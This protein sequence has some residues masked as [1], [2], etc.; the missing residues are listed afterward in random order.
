MLR[1]I[2]ASLFLFIVTWHSDAC[3]TAKKSIIYI[4]GLPCQDNKQKIQIPLRYSK[5]PKE[6]KFN[7]LMLEKS[8]LIALAARAAAWKNNSNIDDSILKKVNAP[9][10]TALLNRVSKKVKWLNT[11]VVH[12]DSLTLLFKGEGGMQINELASF[13]GPPNNLFIEQNRDD[14]LE[15]AS[16]LVQEEKVRNIGQTIEYAS[17]ERTIESS[18]GFKGYKLEHNDI[19]KDQSRSIFQI[20]SNRYLVKYSK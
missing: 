13:N 2:A 9:S 18:V 14:N 1:D 4:N 19:Y 6:L 5:A 3:L 12:K 8:K 20:I 7:N 17:S 11:D 10:A 15:E 16:A